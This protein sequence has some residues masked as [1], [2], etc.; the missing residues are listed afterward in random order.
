MFSILR[1]SSLQ[2]FGLHFTV[3]CLMDRDCSLRPGF[4]FGKAPDLIKSEQPKSQL[5]WKNYIIYD[6]KKK[7]V[8]TFCIGQSLHCTLSPNTRVS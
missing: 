7:I 6:E 5:K 3:E 2:P 1:L 4:P 8:Y